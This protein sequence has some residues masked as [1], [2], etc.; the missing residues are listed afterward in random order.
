VDFGWTFDLDLDLDFDSVF[1]LLDLDLDPRRTRNLPE[2][3][4]ST[5]DRAR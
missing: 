5:L 3:S 1:D 2:R 4:R